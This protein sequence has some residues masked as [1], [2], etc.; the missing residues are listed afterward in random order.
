MANEAV[1]FL[2]GLEADLPTTYNIGYV[3][4]TTDT[5]KIF[6]DTTSSESGRIQL[7]GTDVDDGSL[8]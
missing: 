4:I 6:M 8:D 1:K 7:G 3:Y 5:G 2:R